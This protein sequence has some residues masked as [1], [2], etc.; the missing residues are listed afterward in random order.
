M[1]SNNDSS[2]DREQSAR[3]CQPISP[4]TAE[5]LLR[6]EKLSEEKIKRLN[7]DWDR[8]RFTSRSCAMKRAVYDIAW[9][10]DH[11]A[12]KVITILEDKKIFKNW[13]QGKEEIRRFVKASRVEDPG[14]YSVYSE[15]VEDD[16]PSTSD[17]E[18]SGTSQNVESVSSRAPLMGFE[19]RS[20][21]FKT[22]LLG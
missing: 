9:Y 11:D 13:N 1:V 7:D 17:A 19:K 2:S 8:A 22:D 12:D 14:H 3:Y 6:E 5:K 15:N 10:V 20:K 4:R 18:T 21:D 16:T